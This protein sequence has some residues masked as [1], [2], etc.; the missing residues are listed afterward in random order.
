MSFNALCPSD[1]LLLLLFVIMEY[2][3]ESILHRGGGKLNPCC[4]GDW[5]SQSL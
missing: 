3:P 5:L 2:L 1:P 4:L